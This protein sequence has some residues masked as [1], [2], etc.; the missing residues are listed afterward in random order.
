MENSHSNELL[1]YTCID[2]RFHLYTRELDVNNNSYIYGEVDPTV[3]KMILR[4]ENILQDGDYFLDIGSGCGKMIISLANDVN[5]SHY[6]FTGIEIHQTRYEASMSLLDK[7]D[8]YE[9]VEFIL[10]DYNTLYFRNYNVL[11]C[12]NTIYGEKE[13]DILFDKIIREFTGYFILFEYN[14]IL[15]KYLISSYNVNTSWNNNVSIW[16]FHI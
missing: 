1:D 4:N 9:N 10:G 13:N 15:A 16:L 3:I 14:N 7:Y 12:C 8:L 5:L 2:K 11:Y 6:Y